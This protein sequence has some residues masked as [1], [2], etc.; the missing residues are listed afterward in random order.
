MILFDEITRRDSKMFAEYGGEV[1][2]VGESYGVGHLCDVQFL[3]AQQTCRLFEADVADE[4]CD[5]QAREFLHLSVQVC[6]ADAS[7]GA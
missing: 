7:V 6:T 4:L 1:S 2:Q 5:G 3:F